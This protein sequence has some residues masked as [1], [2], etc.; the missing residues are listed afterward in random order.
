MLFLSFSCYALV[1][2]CLLMPCGYL[3]GKFMIS[4]CEVVPFQLIS[5]V[6]CGALLYR[7]LIFALFLTL[8]A[9]KR[10]Q[11]FA[12]GSVF[13]NINLLSLNGGY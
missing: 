2:V 7:C 13:E 10:C 1:R 12:F 5:W 9:F 4:N 8:N 6:N 3:L 11:I